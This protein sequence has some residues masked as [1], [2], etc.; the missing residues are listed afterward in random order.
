[1]TRRRERFGETKASRSLRSGSLFSPLLNLPC[2]RF[3]CGGGK[4]KSQK[5]RSE[6]LPA[7]GRRPLRKPDKNKKLFDA[8]N[9]ASFGSICANLITFVDERGNRNNQSGF[10]CGG[11]HHRAGGGFLDGGLGLR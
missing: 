11:F 5:H 2:G 3:S 1:M 4:S 7:A 6:A 8:L 10:Q 9:V